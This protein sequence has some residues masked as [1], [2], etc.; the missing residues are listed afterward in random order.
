MYSK[1]SFKY[2]VLIG[3]GIF[4]FQACA[5]VGGVSG[6]TRTYSESYEAV[7]EMVNQAINE[8]KLT[9]DDMAE[10]KDKPVTVYKISVNK[11][12]GK[13]HMTQEGGKVIVRK[14]SNGIVEVE[15]V[16][17]E[18]HYTVPDYQKEDYQRILMPVLD[19]RMEP[20]EASK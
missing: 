8:T 6:D 5:T 2:I 4:I 3:F 19:K 15:V 7:K 11:A 17:P 12:V 10:S 9:I 14:M 16:N 18:Y 1:T 13:T 20:R